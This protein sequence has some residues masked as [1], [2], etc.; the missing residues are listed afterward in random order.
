MPPRCSA[1]TRVG[2]TPPQR[3]SSPCGVRRS[4]HQSG[5]APQVRSGDQPQGVAECSLRSGARAPGIDHP[6]TRDSKQPRPERPLRTRSVPVRNRADHP[7]RTSWSAQPRR[8]AAA[9]GGA[10]SD[11]PPVHRSGRIRARHRHSPDRAG[12]RGANGVFRATSWSLSAPPR[13]TLGRML[14]DENSPDLPETPIVRSRA[15]P[16]AELRSAL[17]PVV[18]PARDSKDFRHSVLAH[19]ASHFPG[20]EQSPRR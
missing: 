16:Y 4:A 8:H 18:Q 7:A 17:P 1:E 11:T 20:Q 19:T 9:P 5:P 13:Y 2:S 14:S 10:Q 3:G 12:A 15:Q 6:R